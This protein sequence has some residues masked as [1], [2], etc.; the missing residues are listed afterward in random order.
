MDFLRDT[1]RNAT[2]AAILAELRARHGSVTILDPGALA[3]EARQTLLSIAS[4]VAPRLAASE[5]VQLFQSL[6]LADQQAIQHRMATKR[7]GNPQAIIGQGRFLEYAP[8]RVILDFFR[9]NPELFLDGHC[10][11]DAYG[12]L[13]YG[14]LAATQEAQQQ[15]SRYYEALLA[16]AVWMA[17]QDAGELSEHSR[18]RLLRA[19]LALILIAPTASQPHE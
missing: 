15:V 8:F 5:P 10:W 2:F 14:N 3:A 4:T 6:L 19:Q 13:D 12:D 16:D 11:D 17:E 7:A 18:E 1:K 9:N